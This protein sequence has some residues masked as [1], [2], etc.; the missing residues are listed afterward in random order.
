MA[1]R[2]IK[3]WWIYQIVM[4]STLSQDRQ[5]Q[6]FFLT[7]TSCTAPTATLRHCHGSTCFT[8]STRLE[9]LWRISCSP[10]IPVRILLPNE[11][12]LPHWTSSGSNLTNQHRDLLSYFNKCRQT[13]LKRHICLET[14]AAFRKNF[15]LKQLRSACPNILSLLRGA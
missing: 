10:G 13:I 8:S 15:L 9:I 11:R 2:T 7:A 1:F 3:V 5:E 4:G 6:P 14:P 12:I